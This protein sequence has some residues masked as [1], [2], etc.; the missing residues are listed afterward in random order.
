M[1][2]MPASSLVLS[3]SKALYEMPPFLCGRQEVGPS[4][5]PVSVAQSPSEEG[6]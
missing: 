1:E 6:W 5:L 2:K 3:L 4:S